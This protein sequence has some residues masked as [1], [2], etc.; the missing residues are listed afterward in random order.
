MS[1]QLFR[2]LREL[3]KVGWAPIKSQSNERDFLVEPGKRI[4]SELRKAKKG[5]R[6]APKN[7]AET[8]AQQSKRYSLRVLYVMGIYDG[9]NRKFLKEWLASDA[10]N[11]RETLRNFPGQAHTRMGGW[12]AIAK[13]GEFAT[14]IDS[15]V[16]WDPAKFPHDRPTLILNGSAD[17]VTAGSQ[18]RRY[19]DKAL[20]GP[21]IFV[22]IDGAGHD[23]LLPDI[24][25]PKTLFD[26]ICRER[27]VN[28]IDCLIAA[29]IT[30]PVTEFRSK[31]KT[32]FE[33]LEDKGLSVTG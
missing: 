24:T 17:V 23:F 6:R 11:F 13:V 4:V 22:E 2:D 33:K 14:D 25:V 27:E 28:P 5:L 30:S 20:N 29:F 15:I 26:R 8:P 16:P 31:A 10:R 1:V 18:A 7:A 32:I 3:R 19:Y 9:L 21:T 12:G